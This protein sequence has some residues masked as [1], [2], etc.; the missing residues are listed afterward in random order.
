MPQIIIDVEPFFSMQYEDNGACRTLEAKLDT[1]WLCREVMQ[2][3]QNRLPPAS[4]WWD[5]NWFTLSRLKDAK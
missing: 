3:M 1:N 4:W 2:Q 5:Y